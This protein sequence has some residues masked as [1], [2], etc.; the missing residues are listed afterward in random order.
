VIGTRK[1][2]GEKRDE[3]IRF[4]REDNRLIGIKLR[5]INSAASC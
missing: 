3:C 5:K 2:H 1:V 4:S